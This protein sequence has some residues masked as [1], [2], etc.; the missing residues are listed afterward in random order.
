[1]SSQGEFVDCGSLKAELE[2]TDGLDRLLPRAQRKLA[3][4]LEKQQ[5]DDRKKDTRRM[6]LKKR[7]ELDNEI[8]H[9]GIEIGQ[10]EKRIAEINQELADGFA[11]GA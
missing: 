6:S 4:R 10:M 11:A 8:F 1:M 2:G 5:D 3:N 9:L 7:E